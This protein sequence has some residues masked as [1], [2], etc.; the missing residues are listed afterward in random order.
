MQGKKEG[1]T[2]AERSYY[3]GGGKRILKDK[4]CKTCKKVFR[5]SLAITKYCSVICAKQNRPKKGKD[6]LCETCSKTVYVRPGGIG[7]IRFCS[8]KCMGKGKLKQKN[9]RTCKTCRKVFEVRPSQEYWRGTAK[10]CSNNCKYDG[11]KATVGGLDKMWA[12]IVKN[13]AG[14]KCEYCGKTDGLNSHHIFSRSNRSTRWYVPNG[15]SLCVSHHVFGNFSAHKAP[16]EFV[17]W[18]KESRGE[19]WYKE[20]RSIAKESVKIDFEEIKTI[21]KSYE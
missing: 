11:K 9:K 12:L 10:F 18:L 20:L 8:M 21:L 4:E 17:E 13:K 5:P 19:D 3:R 6:I 15:V 14:N 1:M 7:K 16:I 2:R